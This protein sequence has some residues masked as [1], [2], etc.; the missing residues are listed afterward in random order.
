MPRW[1]IPAFLL[2]V[3][4]TSIPAAL[5]YRARA[6]TQRTPR[7]NLI[8]DMDY[9]PKY[10]P[11]TKNALFA[12]GRAMRP[13]TPGTVAR[14]Q[15]QEDDHLYRGRTG[16]DWATAI[17]ETALSGV[18]TWEALV[19]RGQD[20]YEIYCT[21]CHG[22]SG[23]GQGMI[24]QR[25]TLL[26]DRGLAIWTPPSSL[27]TDLVRGRAAGHLFNTITNGIRNMP[28]YGSQLKVADRWAVV[29]YIR[30]LQRSQRAELEDVPEDVR[31][32]LR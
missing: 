2:V 5:I 19:A 18:G 15:L 1:L 20:R 12:D 26:M 30:A 16:D 23:N 29:A 31:G 22:Q 21:P 10:L 13:Q 17:P 27:H 6:D 24:A 8:P 28:A 11:Q 32:T 25:G 9:Q 14:G 4:L 3:M 7:I